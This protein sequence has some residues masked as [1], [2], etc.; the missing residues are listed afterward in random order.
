MMQ[1]TEHANTQNLLVDYLD[2]NNL[3]GFR[4]NQLEI[5]NWGTF[6]QKLW[7]INPNGFNSLITG[8]NGSGK[9]TLVDAIITLLVPPQKIIYNQ[10]G[11]AKKGERSLKSYILGSYTNEKDNYN[12]SKPVNLR[13]EGNYSVLLC[14]FYNKGLNKGMTLAQVFSVD[15][16]NV[17]KFF[18]TSKEELSIQEHFALKDDE[19]DIFA[20]K[21]RINNLP[22]TSVFDSYREYGLSYQQFFG[23]KSEKV[24]DLFFQTVSMKNI[25]NLTPFMRNHMLEETDFKDMIKEMLNG[26]KHLTNIY[27]SIQKDKKQIALLEPMMG[28]IKKY[29]TVTLEIEQLYACQKYLSYYFAERK[30]DFLTQFIEFTEAAL[31]ELAIS[32][33]K[34]ESEL[35][36][37]RDQEIEIKIAIGH[38][39]AGQRIKQLQA[40]IEELEAEKNEKKDKQEDYAKDCISVGITPPYN[41]T[42][43]KNTINA[44]EQRLIL[45]KEKRDEHTD[46]ISDL[47]SNKKEM[48]KEFGKLEEELKSLKSR[49]TQIPAKNLAVRADILKNCSIEGVEALPFVGELIKVKSDENKWEGALERLLHNFGLSLLVPE[50]HY[51]TISEYVNQKDLKGRLVYFRVPDKFNLFT[52]NDTKENLVIDKIE[53]K[54]DSR[55]YGWIYSELITKFDLICCDTM[56]D[57]QKETKAITMK[58]Q[59]KG[60]GGR[61]EKDDRRGIL[62]RKYY[63]LGWDN[64][65][66]IRII[67]NQ[68]EDLFQQIQECIKEQSKSKAEQ[69]KLEETEKILNRIL[70]IQRF[71]SIDWQSIVK[72]IDQYQKE[73]I[74]LEKS[75]DH[76]KTLRE[77][78]S[79][80]VKDITLLEDDKKRLESEGT[81][82]EESIR[83][84][85]IELE[86]CKKEL[87]D[88][89]YQEQEDK[90]D[91]SIYL[92]R[93]DISLPSIDE[94]HRTTKEKLI[95]DISK[96]ERKIGELK[97]NI[98]SYMATY[99]TTYSE[100]TFELGTDML[101][102]PA[103]S[104]I[105]A[106]LK[107]DN[108]P[109]HEKDFEEK[110]RKDT[111]TSIANFH[112]E[113]YY[114]A[115]RIKKDIEVINKYLRGLYYNPNT[116]FKLTTEKTTSLQIRDFQNELK[117]CLE[118]SFAAQNDN[119]EEKFQKVKALLDKFK[120]TDTPTNN[121]TNIV[122][123]V[124]NWLTYAGEE[125]S[126]EDDHFVRG[127][128][129]SDGSSGGQKGKL[130]CTILA[131]ALAYRFGPGGNNPESNS[132][133]FVILDEAFPRASD[134]TI[135]YGF[136]L[137]KELNLQV[138]VV[139][140]SKSVDVIADYVNFIHLI[141][142]TDHF[143]DSKILN[144]TIQEYKENKERIQ[145]EV[146]M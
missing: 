89:P 61:H 14:Y 67:E 22:N 139:T 21:K 26:Y 36:Q 78:L 3:K 49:T 66:K 34:K 101:D 33:K 83:V 140:P 48:D 138:L 1:M 2:D 53:L 68:K 128:S 141:S 65:E 24:L 90:P 81:L 51:K 123:D 87:E 32:I 126:C 72:M 11:D 85:K 6:N 43:F 29:E 69:T 108:L 122:T 107:K 112:K 88:S 37:L 57:F 12:N 94:I 119:T 8:T 144:T 121:W 47:L 116:Y 58:G 64:K 35:K 129:D 105:Y 74:E 103:Y 111:N 137:F 79:G 73:I 145:M 46:E 50:E 25:D 125:R 127:Y 91:V 16:G 38:D 44:V 133:R 86:E 17:K 77:R 98:A 84:R 52:R 95:T 59:I 130:A 132:F 39:E 27:E 110:L 30:Y 92:K 71:E 100:E 60:S 63:V 131:S 114:R 102:I 55:F 117:S 70:Y 28:T 104:K 96:K 42:A 18:V 5:F 115:D 40:N 41:E 76:L 143:D 4:L 20:L 23:I 31:A 106:K 80:L 118:G 10:A 113:L 142:N 93:H 120:T 109:K 75:S 62:E 135:R 13:D 134:E 97:G 136:E 7:T 56:E 99:K 45:T 19:I 124:R 146:M 54:T 82:K 15:S 9:S